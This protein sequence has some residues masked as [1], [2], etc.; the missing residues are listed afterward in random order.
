MEHDAAARGIQHRGHR[1]QKALS[2]Q[3]GKECRKS[4][5][6]LNDAAGEERVEVHGEVIDGGAARFGNVF[7]TGAGLRIEESGD[8]ADFD[9]FFGADFDDAMAGGNRGDD[10]IDRR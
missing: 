7:R 4:R 5:E 2:P 1:G 3:R 6:R 10:G 8:V 9:F